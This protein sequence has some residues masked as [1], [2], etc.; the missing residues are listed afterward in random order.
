MSR[1]IISYRAT[2]F[3]QYRFGTGKKK[4]KEIRLESRVINFTA[5]V[6]DSISWRQVG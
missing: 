6:R 3:F 1:I 2:H 4:E 5:L